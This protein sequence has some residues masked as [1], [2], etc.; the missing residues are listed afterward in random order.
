MAKPSR[1]VKFYPFL[2]LLL[3]LVVRL[4]Q[5]LPNRFCRRPR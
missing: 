3:A 2:F 5:L 4:E 1:D